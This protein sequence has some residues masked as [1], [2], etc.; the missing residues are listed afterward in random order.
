MA[1]K[2]ITYV[3]EGSWSGWD[4]HSEPARLLRIASGETAEV[5]SELATDLVVRP[6]FTAPSTP[7]PANRAKGKKESDA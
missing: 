2:K 4:N 5:S 6:D 3:G 7:K 1:T